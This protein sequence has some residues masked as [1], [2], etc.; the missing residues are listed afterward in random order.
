MLSGGRSF[1][2]STLRTE[3]Y[4]GKPP[5]PHLVGHI[6]IEKTAPLDEVALAVS[7]ALEVVALNEDHSGYFEEFPAFVGY[8]LGLRF[9]LLGDPLPENDIR[10]DKTGG[11]ELQ[12]MSYIDYPTDCEIVSVDVSPYFMKLLSEKGI[13]CR[14]GDD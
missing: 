1:R 7:R 10:D 11:F 12:I 2:N 13:K 5:F 6:D 9:A 3:I 14:A 8:A 4:T